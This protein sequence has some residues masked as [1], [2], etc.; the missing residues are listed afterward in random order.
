MNIAIILSGGVGSRM[1]NNIPKQYIELKNKPIISWCIQKFVSRE[2]IDAIVIVIAD[3]WIDYV[4]THISSEI[5][6]FI[7]AKP[8]ETRQFSI[9]NGLNAA[10]DAGFLD[11]DIVIIHDAARPLVSNK[12]IDDCI[13]GLKE[14]YDGVM[15]AL[16]VK[17]TT[18]LTN[19]GT[20]ISSLLDRSK[21]RA[22]QSPE[23]F[24]LG[25]YLALHENMSKD[26]LLKINGSTELAFKAGKKVKIIKGDEGNFKITTPEDLLRFK[27]IIQ[28]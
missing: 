13:N 6:K 22:G 24:R 25:S 1:G 10:K 16:E 3:E 18:Y 11:D 7:F 27:Q 8:G 5:N 15:P 28:G 19:D 21:L 4:K 20:I 17:D 12:I 14:G 23:S 9:Y 2:D 26:E